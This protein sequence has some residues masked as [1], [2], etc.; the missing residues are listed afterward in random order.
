ML[1]LAVCS[2]LPASSWIAFTKLISQWLMHPVRITLGLVIL[3]GFAQLLLRRRQRRILN[4][5][6]ASLLLIYGLA[7]APPSVN[8]AEKVLVSLLPQDT[9]AN[10]DAIVILGRG[11]V[12]SPSRVELAAELWQADRA[13][14]IFTSGMGDSPAMLKML[15]EQGIP[16]A[17]LDG[18]GCSQTTRENALFTVEA[19]QPK[20]ITRILLITDSPHMLRSLLTFQSVGFEVTPIPSPVPREVGRRGKATLVLREYAG[21]VTYGLRGRFFPPETRASLERLIPII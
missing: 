16:D 17:A 14:L 5:T 7:I 11:S 2:A 19:L 15:E 9:G 3:L 12:L 4:L 21:L 6:I 10:A 8:L 13:P 20:G 1:D 18:E